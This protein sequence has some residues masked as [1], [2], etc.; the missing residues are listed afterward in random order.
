MP[1]RSVK[2]DCAGFFLDVVKLI[3]ARVVDLWRRI[4]QRRDRYAAGNVDLLLC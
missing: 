2:F 3:Y 4:E 1:S